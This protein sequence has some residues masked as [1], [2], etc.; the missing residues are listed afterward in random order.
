[1]KNDE[2][3]HRTNRRDGDEVA[4]NDQLESGTSSVRQRE[5][6]HSMARALAAVGPAHPSHLRPRQLLHNCSPSPA[7]RMSEH[8]PLRLAPRSR[9]RHGGKST[10][11]NKVILWGG[12][13]VQLG[14]IPL[15]V[16]RRSRPG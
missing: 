12:G 15:T 13:C 8:P 5:Q 4:L 14:S 1:M 9:G 6:R 10:T 11:T 2:F 3:T 16:I 7:V